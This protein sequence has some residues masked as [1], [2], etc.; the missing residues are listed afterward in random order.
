MS[1]RGNR[2]EIGFPMTVGNTVVDSAPKYE[3]HRLNVS[4]VHTVKG[5]PKMANHAF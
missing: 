4:N 1:A 2:H 3:T 5:I